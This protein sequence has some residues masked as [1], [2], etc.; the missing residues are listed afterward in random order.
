MNLTQYNFNKMEEN[1]KQKKIRTI[2]N[3]IATINNRRMNVEHL[4]SPFPDIEK[5]LI[6]NIKTTYGLD[7]HNL[8]YSPTFQGDSA[9][10]YE[11]I[12][13]KYYSEI[14]R[15]NTSLPCYNAEEL[16]Y[17]NSI[18]LDPN[19]FIKAQIQFS[20][21][22]FSTLEINENNVSDWFLTPEYIRCIKIEDSE[23]ILC[24]RKVLVN[25]KEK[26]LF[27][28]ANM[29]KDNAQHIK[30]YDIISYFV[31][32]ESFIQA[33]K[34]PIEMFT[35]ILD[36]FGII[37]P[38]HRFFF[39]RPMFIFSLDFD[40]NE[41]VDSYM[42]VVSDPVNYRLYNF[43]GHPIYKE[44]KQVYQYRLCYGIDISKYI[45]GYTTGILV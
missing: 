9:E 12:L 39:P 44:G 18:E 45:R 38:H 17:Q 34:D 1:L 28:H 36:I 8:E 23:Y 27:Y 15:D 29:I 19:K 26:V 7:Y 4:E 31:L 21:N 42:D 16:L 32:P 35:L 24:T 30:K 33:I 3:M 11:R 22:L 2:S 37:N 14:Y 41:F 13:N 43:E 20:P 10:E 25:D 5:E 40:L 6:Q